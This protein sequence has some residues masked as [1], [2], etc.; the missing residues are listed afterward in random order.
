MAKLIQ[1]IREFGPRLTLAR[2]AQ[3]P[4]I[5]ELIAARTS[6]NC[7][8]VENALS[9]FKAA[10]LFYAKQGSPVKLEGLGTFTPTIDLAGT[11]N[12]GFRLDA[13][14]DSALNGAG[15]YKG[16]IVNR[17]NMGKSSNEIKA[18]WN[19]AHPN[20]PVGD[21]AAPAAKAVHAKSQLI[22]AKPAKRGAKASPK[23]KR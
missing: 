9:E 8:E 7:G 16:E 21:N 20:D 11:L 22:K 19:Q 6:M 5:A 15:M 17:E 3:T 12:V 13:G 18:M 4:E 2:T 1:A 23:R 10:L 14:I